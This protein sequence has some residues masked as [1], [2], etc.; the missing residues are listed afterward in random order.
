[1][2]PHGLLRTP[3][4]ANIHPTPA[5]GS[6]GVVGGHPNVAIFQPTHAGLKAAENGKSLVVG[7]HRGG[8]RTQDP[9]IG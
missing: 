1:M 7:P 8:D 3:L 6:M 9:F 2:A 4:S 5:Q